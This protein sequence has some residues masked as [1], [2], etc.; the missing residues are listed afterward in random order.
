VARSP[1]KRWG[2]P[3]DIAR[4]VLFL[5]ESNFLT[6]ETITVDGGRSRG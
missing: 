5:L 2:D 3:A 1:L 4:A 6:G